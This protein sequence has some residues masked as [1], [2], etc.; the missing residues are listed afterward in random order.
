[1]PLSFFNVV[2]P[3]LMI[4]GRIDRQS[5]DLH[6]STLELW[7]YFGHVTELS[8]ADGREVLRMRK[9]DSPGVADPIMKP[10]PALSGFRF[11]IWCCVA[12]LHCSSSFF[13]WRLFKFVGESQWACAINS[14][15]LLRSMLPPETT[16]TIGPLP[17]FPLSAAA[18]GSAPA[19][20]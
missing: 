7:L 17:A 10:D 19:P 12:N 20:S 15:N 4:A 5:H 16:A 9:Q 18:S 14:Q 1:M 3:S 6:V 11:K 8:R 2:G 13:C